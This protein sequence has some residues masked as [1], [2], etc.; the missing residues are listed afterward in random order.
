MI[1]KIKAQK[2]K[3]EIIDYKMACFLVRFLKKHEIIF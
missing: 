3:E 1:C 2:L